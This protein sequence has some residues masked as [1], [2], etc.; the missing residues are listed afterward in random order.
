MQAVLAFDWLKVRWRLFNYSEVKN[1]DANE[2]KTY[3]LLVV[4]DTISKIIKSEN[5]A[6]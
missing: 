5:V 3:L 1:R 2:N 4:V 6:S